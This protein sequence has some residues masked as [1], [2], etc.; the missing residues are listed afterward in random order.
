MHVVPVSAPALHD[1][2]VGAWSAPQ[3]GV[4]LSPARVYA[5]NTLFYKPQEARAAAWL[6]EPATMAALNFHEA[7]DTNVHAE[8]ACTVTGGGLCHGWVGWFQIRLG[9]RWLSTSPREA[10]VHW[11]PVFLPIDP[12]LAVD[13]GEV[14]RL[15]IDRQA[16][17]DWTWRM[18]APGGQRRHSTLL[19]L[20]LSP[21]S[22]RRSSRTYTPVL[23]A[24]GRIVAEILSRCD[25]STTIDAIAEGVYHRHPDAFESA[26]AARRLVQHVVAPH[27]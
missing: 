5:A 17:G 20:P 27:A 14:L 22:L 8:T 16:H 11:S 10:P 15:K 12:P 26:E 23:N 3:H 4:D 1:G 2:E 7:T 18:S 25:G 6:A 19:S 21:A 13:T 9:D 24:H